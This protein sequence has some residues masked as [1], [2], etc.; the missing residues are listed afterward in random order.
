MRF[1]RRPLRRRDG[2]SFRLRLA[3]AVLLWVAHTRKDKLSVINLNDYYD[4]YHLLALYL[5]S[6]DHFFVDSEID[7]ARAP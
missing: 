2:W 4:S 1:I 6:L 7:G 5:V 3:G